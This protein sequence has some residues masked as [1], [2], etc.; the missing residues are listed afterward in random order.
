MCETWAPA[1]AAPV[2]LRPCRLF[3]IDKLPLRIVPAA[4][5]LVSRSDGVWH[6]CGALMTLGAI[7]TIGA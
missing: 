7:I 3:P 2:F 4:A 6:R 5:F 1:A